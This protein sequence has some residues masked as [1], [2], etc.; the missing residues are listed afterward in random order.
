LPV[1][2]SALEKATAFPEP[3]FV[4]AGMGSW[5]SWWSRSGVLTTVCVFCR[6]RCR[7]CIGGGIYSGIRH[8]N[9]RAGASLGGW[10]GGWA[11]PTFD[12]L[13]LSAHSHASRPTHPTHCPKRVD[14][15]RAWVG[16]FVHL[17][18]PAVGGL[19]GCHPR[20]SRCRSAPRAQVRKCARW[21]RLAQTKTA[22]LIG[23]SAGA[24]G[25]PRREAQNRLPFARKRLP[26][27]GGCIRGLI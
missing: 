5:A 1:W 23:L 20:A 16:P 2:L 27:G 6:P 21:R 26:E 13:F 24:A 9:S 19:G 18:A 10:V 22:G 8:G 12:Q 25:S 14:R 3:R 17:C 11:L 15:V 4:R 7:R